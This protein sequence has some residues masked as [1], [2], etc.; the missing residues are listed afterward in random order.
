M[1]HNFDLLEE[2]RRRKIAYKSFQ[3]R[4]QVRHLRKEVV[5]IEKVAINVKRHE[6]ET[7]EGTLKEVAKVRKNYTR[8][9]I[10]YLV[11]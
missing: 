5:Q 11:S 8:K 3:K 1:T 4:K 6:E 9:K 10:M 7:S 2:E